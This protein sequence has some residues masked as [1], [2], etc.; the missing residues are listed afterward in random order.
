MIKVTGNSPVSSA[1][2]VGITKEDELVGKCLQGL[3]RTNLTS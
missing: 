2:T 1:E 3:V